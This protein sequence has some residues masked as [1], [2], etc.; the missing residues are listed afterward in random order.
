MHSEIRTLISISRRSV[1]KRFATRP[2]CGTPFAFGETCPSSDGA[3]AMVLSSEKFADHGSARPAWIHAT[4]MRS[5]PTIMPGR[6][7]VNPRAGRDCAAALY[8]KA[9]ITN[10]RKEFDCAEIYVAFSWFEPMLAE[11]LGFADL[12]E[13]WKLSDSGATSLEE[14]GDI[15]WNCSG[16]RALVPIRSARRE[17]CASRKPRSRCVARPGS[18][19]WT[20]P[21]FPSPMRWGGPPSSSRCGLLAARSPEHRIAEIHCRLCES[22]LH[23]REEIPC[24]EKIRGR[25]CSDCR[26][27]GGDPDRYFEPPREEKRHQ[28]RGACAVST[29]PGPN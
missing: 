17:P 26:E 19:R 11:T 16:R 24:R 14:G 25:P 21:G 1:L 7:E 5:E 23:R 28:L 9:G 22:T 12:G 2:C 18:A 15:P 10:P 29:M 8:K 27:G 6:D 4:E 20:G 3:C 13:G